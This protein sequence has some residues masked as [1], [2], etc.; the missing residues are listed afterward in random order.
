MVGI[1]NLDASWGLRAGAGSESRILPSLIGH[2]CLRVMVRVLRG[3]AACN[4]ATQLGRHWLPSG[5]RLLL[6]LVLQTLHFVEVLLCKRPGQLLQRLQV[7]LHV[8]VVS[9]VLV[10]SLLLPTK[11]TWTLIG[12]LC[13]LQSLIVRVERRLELRIVWRKLSL[14]LLLTQL[15]LACLVEDLYWSNWP[16]VLI[17]LASFELNLVVLRSLRA[18]LVSNVV[19]LYLIC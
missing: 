13:L 7:L 10:A 6:L 1:E 18:R 5:C 17:L 3:E 15:A 9:Q 19:L 11:V 8:H 14:T 4:A 12:H 16:L 2:P